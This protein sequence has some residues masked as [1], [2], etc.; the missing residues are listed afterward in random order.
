MGNAALRCCGSPV[1]PRVSGWLRKQVFEVR[2]RQWE[3]RRSGRNEEEQ[4]ERRFDL[5]QAGQSRS[6]W[7]G[8]MKLGFS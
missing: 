1:M 6:S 2:L 8:E 7:V 4:R 3:G 5:T